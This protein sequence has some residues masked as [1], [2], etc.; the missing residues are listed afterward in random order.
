MTLT[1]QQQTAVHQM[2]S[3]ADVSI[4]KP[5]NGL[6][7]LKH[8][9][10]DLVAGLLVA[11]ISTP[12]S[13][14]IAIASGAPPITGLTSAIIAGFVLPFLGGS[15]VTISGPAAGLAPVLYSAM[16]TLGAGSLEAGY[17]LLL[18]VICMA[19]FI[20]IILSKLKAAKY[21]AIFPAPV[22]EGML[23]AIG[24]MIIMKQFPQ[25]I[26]H[27]Y[28]AHEF[29][30]MF[31][32][33]PH[34][35]LLANP[36][37][38]AF[39]LLTLGLIILIAKLGD[40]SK[41]VK[42]V[43]PPMIAVTLVTILSQVIHLDPQFLINIPENPLSHGL[44]FPDFQGIIGSSHLWWTAIMIAVT[45]TLID[46][47]ESL[48]TINA[49]DKIDPYRRKSDSNR[50][51]LAMGVSNICSSLVGGLTII[52]GGVKS[53]ANIMAGGR[54]QW[55]NF[56]NAC[57]LLTFLLVL[58]PIINCLP[59]AA[60]A[61]VLVYTGFKLCRPRVWVKTRQVG[62]D[63]FAVYCFTVWVTLTTDLMWGIILGT[64]LMLV[65]NAALIWTTA[66]K[67]GQPGPSLPS[68]VTMMFQSPV[69][70]SAVGQPPASAPSF[71]VS[72]GDLAQGAMVFLP[73]A[74]EAEAVYHMV[75]DKPLVCSNFLPLSTALEGVPPETK[76]IYLHVTND[77][78]VIDHTTADHLFH[79]IQRNK[80]E[81]KPHIEI[82][83][84]DRMKKLSHTENCT[85][86]LDVEQE[87]MAVLG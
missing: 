49:I 10:H 63:Q 41:W 48:A 85:R 24:L 39:G 22:V 23:T 64:V 70:Q 56:F 50:T 51:L 62:L 21:A 18:P 55:A 77:V 71:S 25:L 68:L 53:T 44:V 57:F 72:E 86:L 29:W 84:L 65:L 59:I 73:S 32:E 83:G 11:M 8:W 2:P 58:R 3:E 36:K 34:E 38:V 69:A 7:G 15:F 43:P 14:G 17:P 35:L 78:S 47:I 79:L 76:C 31:F 20:Q 12:F 66:R 6:A 61:A 52:P 28:L 75:L 82:I 9:R 19:G 46:G 54:T 60:L 42:V 27:K 80:S 1:P 33:T 81:N 74:H 5:Q 87:Q 16:L 45:L 4:E 40:G 30:G 67:N 13:I 37:V 26:G